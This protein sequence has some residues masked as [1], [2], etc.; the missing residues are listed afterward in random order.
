M[1]VEALDLALANWGAPQR[2]TLGFSSAAHDD[3]ALERAG[4][5]LGL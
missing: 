4:E 3:D 2:A 1:P 5:A